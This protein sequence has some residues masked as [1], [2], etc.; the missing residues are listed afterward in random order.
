MTLKGGKRDTRVSEQFI[1]FE[2]AGGICQ[3]NALVA[4]FKERLVPEE[5]QGLH[6]EAPMQRHRNVLSE[7]QGD[8]LFMLERQGWL[9]KDADHRTLGASGKGIEGF[10]REK[11]RFLKMPDMVQQ[12]DLI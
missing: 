6:Q 10:A 9:G 1:L 2:E 5:G 11:R 8:L 12:S 7:L 3:G 4:S